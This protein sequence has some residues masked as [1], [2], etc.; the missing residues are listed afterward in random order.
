MMGV[1]IITG[2]TGAVNKSGA[3]TS[4]HADKYIQITVKLTLTRFNMTC[5]MQK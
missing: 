2:V 4:W 5:Q 1:G 3:L